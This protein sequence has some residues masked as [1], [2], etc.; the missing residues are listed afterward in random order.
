MAT[1]LK[2][3]LLTPPAQ[4]LVTSDL[5]HLLHQEQLIRT[6]LLNSSSPAPELSLLHSLQPLMVNQQL[7]QTAQEQLQQPQLIHTL[8]EQHLLTRKV[9]AEAL[10]QLV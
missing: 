9:L 7:L 10:L 1:P 3:S 6:A 8:Q 4:V 2:V 5:V